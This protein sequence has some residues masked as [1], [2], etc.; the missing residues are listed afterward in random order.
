MRVVR[1]AADEEAVSPVIGIILMVAV[2][3]IL[4][5]VIGTFVLGIGQSTSEPTP[6]VSWEFEYDGGGD[7]G[8]S[9]GSADDTLTVTHEGG[10]T[11]EENLQVQVG[12]TRVDASGS[13][14]TYDP[15]G[16]FSLPFGAG[17]SVTAEEDGSDT[18]QSGDRVFVVYRP[19]VPEFRALIGESQVPD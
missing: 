10:D 19:D 14:L 3:V 4:A 1:V 15:S 13:N 6:Q 18:I 2:T 7:G 16:G 9:G 5:A 8:F 17:D 12:G 11:I